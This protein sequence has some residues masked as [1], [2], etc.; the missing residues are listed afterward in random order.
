MGPLGSIAFLP[1]AALPKRGGAVEDAVTCSTDVGCGWFEREIASSAP[2]GPR[3][4]Q[5]PI[6]QLGRAIVTLR[7]RSTDALLGI[8]WI[9][10]E[11]NMASHR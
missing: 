7:R 9:S 10:A 3:S 11:S 4:P 2:S 1:T 8:E 5:N 6:W